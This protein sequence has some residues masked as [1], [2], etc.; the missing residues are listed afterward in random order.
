MEM[1][2]EFNAGGVDDD[3][4]GQEDACDGLGSG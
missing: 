1:E 2:V 3:A 4:L